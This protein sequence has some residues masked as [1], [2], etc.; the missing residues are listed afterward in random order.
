MKLIYSYDFYQSRGTVSLIG[1]KGHNLFYVNTFKYESTNCVNTKWAAS[2]LTN[3]TYGSPT[4]AISS[5]VIKTFDDL[6]LSSLSIISIYFSISGFDCWC[7]TWF[8]LWAQL[9]LQSWSTPSLCRRYWFTCQL[10]NFKRKWTLAL[11][12]RILVRGSWRLEKL[13]AS[14]QACFLKWLHSQCHLPRKWGQNQSWRWK[15]QFAVSSIHDYI[16]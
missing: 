3:R 9:A 11:I 2:F 12:G 1:Q 5:S 14:L 6:L 8:A 4:L 15:P 10:F 13:C 16:Y 7:F